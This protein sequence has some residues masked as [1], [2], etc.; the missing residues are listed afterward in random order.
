M[1]DDEHD[2]VEKG[3]RLNICIVLCNANGQVL[4]AQRNDG[5]NNWQ[6]PQG[7]IKK[8]ESAIQAMYRE[9]NEEVG[10]KPSDAHIVTHTS[11]WFR[12][13]IPESR[14]P[15]MS[16]T[17]GQKQ[18]W[19]LLSMLS[20]DCAIDL[21]SDELESEFVRWQWVDFWEPLHRIVRF[22]RHVYRQGLEALSPFRIQG[23]H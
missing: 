17:V 18:R 20:R 8:G 13:R 3:Y 4:I 6:F 19:F 7:G 15:A 9:L 23:T 14:R 1:L 2:V 12:Y 16:K 11:R 10:L 5:R 21:D 22:K